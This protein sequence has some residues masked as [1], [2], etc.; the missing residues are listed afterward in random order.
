MGR[1][2]STE[3]KKTMASNFYKSLDH[4][5]FYFKQTDKKTISSKSLVQELQVRT[6]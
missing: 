6:R 2:R 3:W 4:R 1:G 5:S